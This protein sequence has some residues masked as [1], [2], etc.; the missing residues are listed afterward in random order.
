MNLPKKKLSKKLIKERQRIKKHV[1]AFGHSPYR[2]R[3]ITKHEVSLHNLDCLK[4]DIKDL[5]LLVKGNPVVE[6]PKIVLN[7]IKNGIVWPIK[8]SKLNVTKTASS[9][10]KWIRTLGS[11]MC[12][13]VMSKSNGGFCGTR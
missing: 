5:L 1:K 3:K 13:I 6:R 11:R 2:P 7:K 4:D 9:T 10:L 12:S 8:P